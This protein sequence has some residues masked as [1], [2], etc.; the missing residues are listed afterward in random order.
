MV[1]RYEI[2][3]IIFEARNNNPEARSYMN[4]KD[5]KEAEKC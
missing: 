1:P 4:K 3:T 2:L 5:K